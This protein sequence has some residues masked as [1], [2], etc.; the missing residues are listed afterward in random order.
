[1]YIYIYICTYIYIYTYV[2]HPSQIPISAGLEPAPGAGGPGPSRS[3][4]GEPVRRLGDG[5][6][7][8]ENLRNISG[9][10]MEQFW[11]MWEHLGKSHGKIGEK[12][13]SGSKELT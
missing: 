11:N 1:M 13:R 3:T 9:K 5:M 12:N 4:G 6:P 2:Y 8:W 10:C 7:V